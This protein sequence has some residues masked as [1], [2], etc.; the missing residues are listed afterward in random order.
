MKKL[1]IL[2]FIVVLFGC[3]PKAPNFEPGTKGFDCCAA[4]WAVYQSPRGSVG[5]LKQCYQKCVDKYGDVP[6]VSSTIIESDG[7]TV[8]IGK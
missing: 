8:T 5:E 6:T 1:F 7:H 4:C 2:L 3:A